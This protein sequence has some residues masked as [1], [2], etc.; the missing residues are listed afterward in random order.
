MKPPQ[1]L[2]ETIAEQG[3]RVL[4][5]K[6]SRA[7]AD[8]A[9]LAAT[10]AH[11]EFGTDLGAAVAAGLFGK[12]LRDHTSSGDLFQ[13]Q[14][15]PGLPASL[16]IAPKR[17]VPVHAMTAADLD[18]AKKMLYARTGNAMDGAKN[19]AEKERAV[20]DDFYDQVR[21]LLTDGKTVTDALAELAAK[22]A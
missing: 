18:H 22:A 21:P 10:R 17:A 14:P 16:L 13:A 11:P 12:W 5:A 15:F 3:V 7:D 2:A 6:A 9:V 1:W 4:D 8:A 19:A 20:F